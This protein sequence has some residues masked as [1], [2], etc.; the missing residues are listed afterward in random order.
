MSGPWEDFGGT[1][2]AADSGPWQDFAPSAP[3]RGIGEPEEELTFGEKSWMG[4]RDIAGRIDKAIGS[5]MIGAAAE[6][7]P[8]V[9]GSAA[10]RVAMGMA[11]PGV[12]AVQLAANLVGAGE[13][14]NRWIAEVEG[15]YEA[16]RK[17]AGSEGFDPARL[18]GNVAITAPLGMI[19]APARTAAGM[20]AKGAVQ[21]AAGGALA[22]VADAEGLA[23]FLQKKA[24][25]TGSGAAGGA[26][27]SPVAGALARVVS[28]KASTNAELALLRQEGVRPTVG[29]AL[30]GWANQLEEK[31]TSLPIMGDA[32]QAARRGATRSFNEAAINRTV[33]PIGQSVKGSGQEAV[34]KAGDALSDA[35]EAAIGK[36]KGVVFDT[37]EFN[38]DLGNLQRL[39]QGLEPPHLRRFER[40]LENVVLARMSPNGGMTG[41]TLQDVDSELGALAR[42]YGK[43]QMAGE[44]E[45]SDAVKELQSIMRQQ[46]ARSEPAFADALAKAREGWA[47]LVRVE[48]AATKAANQG[49]VFTPGQLNQA[50]RGADSSVRRRATARGDALMQDLANAAQDVIGN[51][52]PDSGTV[53]R[54]MANAGALGSAALHPAIPA[55][56][57]AGAAAYA[58]PVQRAL[59]AAVSRRPDIAPELANRLRLYL[60]GP[61][62]LAGGFGAAGMQ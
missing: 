12:A 20:A 30:G 22:P 23:D 42:R 38:R 39:A 19:G 33:A 40:H 31:L 1:A 5:R 29:Q 52:Y 46:V 3:V 53:G 15:K 37:P 6:A 13:P 26:I 61:L 55:A 56:L 25:Q 11:D 57:A 14:V 54:F 44:Q 17:A 9:R 41:R 28:P 50:V 43:S 10:G 36:V 18:A 8:N 16:A 45:L 47:Q 51:K 35:F 48:G 7:L 49:G 21:G 27:L 60:S 34:T 2:Q 32:I 24:A 62:G 4:L 59:V 58:P